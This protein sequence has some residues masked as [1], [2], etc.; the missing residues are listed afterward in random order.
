MHL[1]ASPRSSP[2]TGFPI[3]GTILCLVTSLLCIGL[4]W[5]TDIPLGVPGEWEWLRSDSPESLTWRLAQPVAAAV[6]YLGLIG[7]GVSRIE[8]AGLG[9]LVA[10]LTGL[11]IAG[12]G[13]LWLIQQSAPPGCDLTKSAWVLYYPKSSG[14]FTEAREHHHEFA[15]YLAGYEQT[16]AAGDVLHLGTH[17]PGLIIAFELLL[18]GV[19][20][21]PAVTSILRHTEPA[22]VGQGFRELHSWSMQ[23]DGGPEG[24]VALSAGDRAV[25]WLAFLLVQVAGC[26]TVFP[27]FW[28]VQ[29]DV[30][31]RAA[32]LAT[33]FWPLIPA[34]AIFIPKSDALFPLV[35]CLVLGCGL[36]AVE[37]R[38]IRAG[39]WGLMTG[40][41]LWMGLILSL[42]PLVAGVWAL[43]AGVVVRTRSAES[44]PVSL[45]WWIRELQRGT[46]AFIG[47]ALGL[48]IPTVL[49][50]EL[51]GMNLIEVWRGSYR[52]HAGFYLQF[53]RTYWKW[54]LVNPLEFAI[55]S[56]VPLASLAAAGLVRQVRER[57][58][59][60]GAVSF[61]VTWGLLYL[62]GKNQ[63]EAARLWLFLMPGLCWIAA[64][65]LDHAIR[66]EAARGVRVWPWMTPLLLQLVVAMALATR[67]GGFQY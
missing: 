42:A 21:W 17:P 61:L 19:E 56:G 48:A 2:E 29:R 37:S 45:G 3:A 32:W 7:L 28:V 27:L 5:F 11:A 15:D 59:S 49:F 52:N 33:A 8:R 51:T 43:V 39:L 25:L 40:L 26:L 30:S 63:G 50:S 64:G 31:R 58:L 46:P 4:V 22:E 62:S 41:C 65:W 12:F 18:R 6:L 54:L 57:C 34:L 1:Q 67:V 53:P 60:V 13:W 44:K 24:S 35:T 14:Y 38:G 10:W 55:A 20:R 47:L 23:V 36:S 66:A 16:I 9:G